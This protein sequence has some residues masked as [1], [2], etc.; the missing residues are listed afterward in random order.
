[1][2]PLR[3]AQKRSIIRFVDL[4]AQMGTLVRVIESGS[5]SAAAR[6]LGVSPAAVSRQISD[7]ERRLGGALVVRSTRSLSVTDAGRR[8]YEHAVRILREVEDAGASVR[9]TRTIRGRLAISAPVTFGLARVFPVLPALLRKHAELELDVRLEDRIV[10]LVGEG[11]DIA[12]RVGSEPPDS[13]SV[14]AHSLGRYGRRAV[15]APAYL[16]RRAAPKH[17]KALETHESL[18]HV[19]DDGLVAGWRFVRD[20]SEERVEPRGALRTNTVFALREAALAGVGIALL[21]EWLVEEDVAAGR[22]RVL[23]PEWSASKVAVIALH[24][25]ELKGIPRVRVFLDHVRSASL[26]AG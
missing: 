11:V 17:P 18:L 24:R 25:A 20:G 23:L 15:A 10:D 13:T 3:H 8:Y 9:A 26:G 4:L 21:P 6:S 16:R 12:I 19:G 2:A 7:L 22:L 5:L 1:M 14:V